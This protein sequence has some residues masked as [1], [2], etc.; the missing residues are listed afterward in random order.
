MFRHSESEITYAAGNMPRSVYIGSAIVS[1]GMIALGCQLG[2]AQ[3]THPITVALLCFVLLQ[4]SYGIVLW[5]LS[6]GDHSRQGQVF[7]TGVLTV[8]AF[9]CSLLALAGPGLDWPLYLVTIAAYFMVYSPRT[10]SILTLFLYILLGIAIALLAGWNW[11]VALANWLNLLLNFVFVAIFL[12]VLRVSVIQKTR[13][14]SLLRQLERS[15]A[16]LEQAHQQLQRYANTVEEFAVVRERTRL[17]REIHD[18]LGHYLSLLH[19]QLGTMSKV[20]ARDPADLKVEITEAR[21]LAGQAIHEVRNAVAALRPTS[22][23]TL[24]LPGAL[25]QLCSEFARSS[26]ETQ[27]TLDLAEQLPD[28]SQDIQMAFYRAAQEALTNVRKHTRASNV[29]LRLCYENEILEL[30]VLDNGSE[31]ARSGEQLP[32]GSGLAG[33]GERFALLGGQVTYGFDE[34]GGYRV[35]ARLRIAALPLAV[36]ASEVQT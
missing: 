16:E 18:T 2:F 20:Y 30:V 35:T 25:A 14:E 29:L 34:A 28:I 1:Y 7:K 31:V 5:R 9:A 11:P 27:L 4:I 24:N 3:A 21:Q 12:F 19:I 22:I 8:L 33:L 32:G 26:E 13:A 6:A 10:A 23:T 36:G 17:A 15:N